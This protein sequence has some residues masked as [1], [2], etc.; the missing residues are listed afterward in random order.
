M[1]DGVVGGGGRTD[2]AGLYASLKSINFDGNVV[3]A[4]GERIARQW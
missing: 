1:G 2:Q 4:R 3:R